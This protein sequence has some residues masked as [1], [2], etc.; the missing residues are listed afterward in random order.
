MIEYPEAEAVS[1][2]SALEMI[3]VL[4]PYAEKLAAAPRTGVGILRALIQATTARRPTDIMHLL[5]LVYKKDIAEIADELKDMSGEEYTGVLA[6][7]FANN[8]LPD[9]INAG[10]LLGLTNVR[11]DDVT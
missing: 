4:E 5:A 9:L 1:L 7:A 8:P 2:V 11:W 3:K 10:Y 6:S